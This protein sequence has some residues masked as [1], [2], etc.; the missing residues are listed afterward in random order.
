MNFNLDL[1]PVYAMLTIHKIITLVNIL[2]NNEIIAA[3]QLFIGT[4][5]F[6]IRRGEIKKIGDDMLDAATGFRTNQLSGIDVQ[7]RQS[8]SLGCLRSPCRAFRHNIFKCLDK[9]ATVPL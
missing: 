4:C 2:V 3:V 1:R 8:S 5:I 6:R 7:P 9:Y